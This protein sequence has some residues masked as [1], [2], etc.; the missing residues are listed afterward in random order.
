[1]LFGL[2]T[3]A[4]DYLAAGGYVM[5]PLVLVF[6]FYYFISS[7]LLPDLA[8][9]AAVSALPAPWP[10]ALAAGKDER[11]RVACQ[12]TDVTWVFLNFLIHVET[13]RDPRQ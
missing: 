10:G 7:Q 13:I 5:P 9:A 6:I 1:M 2:W 4:S 8:V 12:Q 11:Q 3:T